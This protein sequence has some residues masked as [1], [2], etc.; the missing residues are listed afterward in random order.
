MTLV[1]EPM[2]GG[3]TFYPRLDGR[4]LSALDVGRS[5]APRRHRAARGTEAVAAVASLGPGT[6]S[7]QRR[8]DPG[9]TRARCGP[10]QRRAPGSRIARRGDLAAQRDLLRC[11]ERRRAG[12]GCCP[13]VLRLLAA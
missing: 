2:E 1:V 8:P 3:G 6:D 10:R 5:C 11:D 12:D 13:C 7:D 4:E 9:G